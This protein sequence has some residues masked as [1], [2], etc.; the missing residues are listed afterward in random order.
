MKKIFTFL[1]DI[2]I[3]C[4]LL[5]ASIICAYKAFSNI[6]LLIKP[7]EFAAKITEVKI[8]GSR[9]GR[10]CSIVFEYE[11]ENEKKINEVT[12]SWSIL[13]G[14]GN[15]IKNDYAEGKTI[16]ICKNNFGF[17]QVKARIKAEIIENF[18]MLIISLS[19]LV[20]F[21]N[22]FYHSLPKKKEAEK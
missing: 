16:I 10:N 13:S 14:L 18:I 15:F 21:I 5:L 19:M 20:F 7:Q 1:A 9:N 2:L 6:S 4:F 22:S 3:I 11:E 8:K 12:F 17:Y